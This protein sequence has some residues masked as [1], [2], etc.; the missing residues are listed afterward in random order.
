MRKELSV[1]SAIVLVC[2]DAADKN[3]NASGYDYNSSISED[4]LSYD[5]VKRPHLNHD[6][7]KRAP[8]KN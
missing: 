6:Y 5:V 1:I 4:N 8:A 3:L 7:S 2:L